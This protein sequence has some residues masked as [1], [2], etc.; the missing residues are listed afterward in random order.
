MIA[1]DLAHSP[2]TGEGHRPVWARLRIAGVR[3]RVMTGLSPPTRPF[4]CGA[5]MARGVTASPLCNRW[6]RA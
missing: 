1:D 4:S 6:P 5:P 3:V 2:F